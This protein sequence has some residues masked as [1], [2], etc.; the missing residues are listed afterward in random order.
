MVLSAP[1]R[2]FVGEIE[3]IT[4]PGMSNE[5]VDGAEPV[6]RATEFTAQQRMKTFF[7]SRGCCDLESSARAPHK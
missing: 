4:A 1:G 5:I 6:K 7:N 3:A 2:T